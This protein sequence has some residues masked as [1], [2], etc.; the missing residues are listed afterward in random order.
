MNSFLPWPDYNRSAQSLD[1]RRLGKQ[2]VEVLQM[3]KAINGETKGWVNH[4][5]TIMWEDYPGALVLYGV[6]VCDQWTSLGFD[7]TC[8]DQILQYSD[9][10]TSSYPWWFGDDYLHQTHRAMLFYKD[11]IAYASFDGTFPK[12]IFDYWW[13]TPEE[14]KLMGK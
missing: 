4:P 12:N 9:S 10:A 6:A 8:K 1:R 7:D 3:L 2:R 14:R 13:P 11:S 5:C